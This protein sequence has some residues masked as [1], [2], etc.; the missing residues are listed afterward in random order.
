MLEIRVIREMFLTEVAAAVLV[1][2]NE[3]VSLPAPAVALHISAIFLR[4]ILAQELR[5]RLGNRV[6][7]LLQFVA[8]NLD[9]VQFRP[10]I[11]I[12]VH[13]NVAV[14]EIP[15]RLEMPGRLETQEIQGT[16]ALH[17]LL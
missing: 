1:L 9:Q 4:A 6:F 7:F 15:G 10:P 17:L 14:Q 8:V 12:L 13:H 11:Q 5:L 3:L 2:V 16:P